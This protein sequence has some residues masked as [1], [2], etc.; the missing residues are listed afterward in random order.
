MMYYK[1]F[2]ESVNELM[3]AKKKNHEKNVFKTDALR[4]LKKIKLPRINNH[5]WIQEIF[6]EIFLFF[7]I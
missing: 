5:L 2:I 4:Q 1:P 7:K 6:I 3:L